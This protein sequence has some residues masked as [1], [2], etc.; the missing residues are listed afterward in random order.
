MIDKTFKEM[1]GSEFT[2]M[3]RT[4]LQ[5]PLNGF[6]RFCQDVKGYEFYYKGRRVYKWELFD[7]GYTDALDL[8]WNGTDIKAVHITEYYVI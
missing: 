6:P 5:Y 4:M 7:W 1:T 8:I 3:Q 2:K